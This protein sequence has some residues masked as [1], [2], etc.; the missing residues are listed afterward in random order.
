VLAS[1]FSSLGHF[2]LGFFLA[3]VIEGRAYIS[4]YETFT[5][6]RFHQVANVAIF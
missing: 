4:E 1:V 6:Q 5:A 2:S 3:S